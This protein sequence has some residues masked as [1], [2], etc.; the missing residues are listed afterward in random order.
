[1]QVLPGTVFVLAEDDNLEGKTTVFL[2]W[3]LFGAQCAWFTGTLTGVTLP[4]NL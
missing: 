1:L 3:L 2:H 4:E